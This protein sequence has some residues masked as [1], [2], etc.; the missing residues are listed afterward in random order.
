MV[1]KKDQPYSKKLRGLDALLGE[2]TNNNNPS[3]HQSLP[4]KSIL[5]PAQQPRRYFDPQKQAQLVLSL[6]KFGILEPILVRPLLNDQY[7]LV[8]GERRYRAALELNLTE[9]PVIIKEFSDE[10]ALQVALIENLQRVD[11]NPVEETEGILKLLS[12]QLKQEAEQIE[13]LLY[14]MQNE[15]KG[16]VTQN[17]L[18]N[19]ESEQIKSIFESLGIIQWQ[20]FVSSRLPLLKLPTEI[21]EA[22]RAGK[23]AYTK[24]LV[25]AR[26]KDETERQVLLTEAITSQLSLVQIKQRIKALMQISPSPSLKQRM[27]SAT[28]KLYTAKCWDD[29]T[30]QKKLERLLSEIESLLLDSS[31]KKE[32]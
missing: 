6:K 24:A 32:K 30:K 18:G 23:I 28:K 7:E 11:L 14:R 29:P 2:P 26:L 15:A 21:L 22:I 25:I 10:E 5:K 8:A 31:S 20:S 17:V 12:I 13:T 9:V 4:L 27:K 1:R 3:S 19:S 16:K